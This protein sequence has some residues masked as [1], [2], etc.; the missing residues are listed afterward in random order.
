MRSDRPAADTARMG[1]ARHESRFGFGQAAGSL[2]AVVIA[3][4]VSQPWLKLDLGAAFKAALSG[5]GVSAQAAN[6][7]LVVGSRLRGPDVASSSQVAALAR[8]LGVQPTGWEQ[9][10]IGAIVVL[11]LAGLAL[12]GVVRSVLADTAWSARANA[13]I[14]GVAGFGS[15]L[16]AGVTLWL[17]APAPQEAMRPDLGMWVLV[18]GAVLLLLGALTLGN[19]RRRPFLDDVDERPT[20]P[21]SFDSTEHLAYSHGAWVPRGPA[22]SER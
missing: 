20:G 22:E 2:G 6:D 14:L 18:A 15:L 8:A 9:E 12:I 7:I 4:S 17:R 19:N 21:G 16:V 3:V 13:P 1:K 11:V 5:S 10:M